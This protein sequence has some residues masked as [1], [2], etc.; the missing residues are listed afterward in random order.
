[1][2]RQKASL[3]SIFDS[4]VLFYLPTSFPMLAN[5]RFPSCTFTVFIQRLY[6]ESLPR[7]SLH[8]PHH[9]LAAAQ[10]LQ[11][12]WVKCNS[13]GISYLLSSKWIQLISTQQC[14]L[15]INEDIFCYYIL[16]KE[17]EVTSF[18][19]GTQIWLSSGGSE[20]VPDSC[21]SQQMDLLF[22]LT[23]GDGNLFDNKWR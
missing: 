9:S 15:D 1:M 23:V 19:Q 17:M 12:E 8:S 18:S 22:L 7:K 4:S 2:W 3:K 14:C 21:G 6:W 11:I 5:A 10:V 20:V 13:S 16:L